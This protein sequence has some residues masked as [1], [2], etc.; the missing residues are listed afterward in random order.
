M[1]TDSLW[2]KLLSH[3]RLALTSLVA[4][5][6]LVS[7]L[8]ALVP[9]NSSLRGRYYPNAA[10][11]PNC[12]YV[13][14]EVFYTSKSV[15]FKI[16]DCLVTNDSLLTVVLWYDGTLRE[17]GEANIGLLRIIKTRHIYFHQ[18]NCPVNT[19]LRCSTRNSSGVAIRTWTAYTFN[20]FQP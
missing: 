20:W 5:G 17:Y 3:W 11:A 13:P 4:L 15:M 8:F 10:H 2:S 1:A 19:R 6:I 16:S 9:W 12:P 7:C 18:L 14:F